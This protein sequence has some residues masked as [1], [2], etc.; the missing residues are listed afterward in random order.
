MAKRQVKAI[1]VARRAA[2]KIER[3]VEAYFANSENQTRAYLAVNPNVTYGTAAVEGHRLI[4]NPKVHAMIEKRRAEMRAQYALTA[5]RVFQEL[6]RLSYFDPRKL[7]DADG[8]PIP[9]HKLDDDT[10]AALAAIELEMKGEG[11]DAVAVTRWR[12]FDKISA[13]EK[14]VKILRLYDK[15]P[16]PPPDEEGRQVAEDPRETAR[17]MAFLLRAGAAAEERSLAKPAPVRRK[18]LVL[19]A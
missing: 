2:A 12:P 7:V 5:E 9:L 16:P 4:K 18:K 15:P 13:L 3:F 6:G 17:R 10:A 8:R 1:G 11:K 14:A 19:P